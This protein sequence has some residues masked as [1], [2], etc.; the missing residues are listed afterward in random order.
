MH[1]HIFRHGGEFF[2]SFTLAGE[3]VDEAGPFYD[4]TDAI[5]AAERGVFGDGQVTHLPSLPQR[6]NSEGLLFA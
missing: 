3:M 5:F 2:V 1:A 6:F 4:E